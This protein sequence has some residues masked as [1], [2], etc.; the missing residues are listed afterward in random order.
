MLNMKQ[1]LSETLLPKLQEL[2]S[3]DLKNPEFDWVS[4]GCTSF[5]NNDAVG[6]WPDEDRAG[7]GASGSCSED[8]TS[9]SESGS[10]RS[11]PSPFQLGT[12]RKRKYQDAFSPS[13]PS[14]SCG[15][16]RIPTPVV[17]ALPTWVNSSAEELDQMLMVPR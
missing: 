2:K 5:M 12:K 4:N 6:F 16:L 17:N 15:I 1:H 9:R 14:F 8:G 10:G 3:E 13:R 11:Y 7:S